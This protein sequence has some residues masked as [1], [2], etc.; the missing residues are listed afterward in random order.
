MLRIVITTVKKTK[1][2]KMLSGVTSMQLSLRL[3]RE[4][5]EGEEGGGV[6]I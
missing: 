3:L 5:E 1:E 6:I 4:K 2:K